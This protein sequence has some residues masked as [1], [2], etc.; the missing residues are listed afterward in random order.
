MIAVWLGRPDNQ[1][2]GSLVG[3]ADAVPVLL[4]AFAG[5]DNTRRLPQPEGRLREILAGRPAALSHLAGLDAD[6][7]DPL[8][9]VFPT[10][11]A[12]IPLAEGQPLALRLSGGQRPFRL[13]VDGLPLAHSISRQLTWRPAGPGFYTLSVVDGAG[14]TVEARVE[15][16]DTFANLAALR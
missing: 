10:D 15:I 9:L 6:D 16:M 5:L 1:P 7:P 13:F 11:E 2:T 8:S 12:A 3:L 4:R 14:R